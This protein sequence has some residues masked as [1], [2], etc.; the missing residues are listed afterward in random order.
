M[1]VISDISLK[2]FEFWES[3][4]DTANGLTDEQLDMVEQAIEEL[5]PD[6]I[7]DVELNDIFRF[8][9]D[10]V[11]ETAG[12]WPKYFKVI[13][14]CGLVEYVKVCNTEDMDT[15]ESAGV[16]FEQVSDWEVDELAD[17]DSDELK[18]FYHTHFF[19][20]TSK[21]KHHK[22]VIRCNGDAEAEDFK[23]AFKYAYIEEINKV[24]EDGIEDAED[25]FDYDGT[26]IEL[27]DEFVYDEDEMYDKYNIPV[28]AVKSISKLILDPNDEFGYYDAPESEA[29]NM[30]YADELTDEENKSIEDFVKRLNEAMPNGFIIDWDDEDCGSPSFS[31]NPEF[32]ESTT[33][34]TLR[35]YG[36]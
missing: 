30:A 36:K 32:G 5:H 24:P 20:V 8:D 19:N 18:D 28:W 25:W 7:E 29:L 9:R 15:L 16:D 33:C 11:F 13:A 3:A 23:E 2:D 12:E 22:K 14:E 27:V 21:I 17:I 35:V 10:W 34:V 1:K 4:Q 31:T 6:G 26:Y